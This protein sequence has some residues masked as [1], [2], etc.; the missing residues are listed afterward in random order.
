MAPERDEAPADPDVKRGCSAD[1]RVTVRTT[2]EESDLVAG[3][4]APDNTDSMDVRVDVDTIVCTIE[5][6]TTGG[7]RST[8]DDY[9]VNL[10]VADRVI[11]S[12]RTHGAT[13]SKATG[14]GETGTARADEADTHGRTKRTRY[15][16]TGRPTT[17]PQRNTRHRTT[18]P[19]RR[20]IGVMTTTT[21][22]IT[23]TTTTT[24]TNNE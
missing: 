23:T 5:R 7:L 1:R 8:T 12:G 9:V 4:L 20:S 21:T 22:T 18:L 17:G 3:A 16:G 6:P 14:L 15:G 13:G 19:E 24:T 10:R 2:H 11:A